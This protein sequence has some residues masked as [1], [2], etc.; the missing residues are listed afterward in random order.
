MSRQESIA[1]SPDGV[2]IETERL[3]LRPHR[4]ADLA[5]LVELASNWEVARWLT[6]VPHPYGEADASAWISRVRQEHE[7]GRPRLF[8]IAR[9]SDDRLIGNAG[10]GRRK[11]DEPNGAVLG[12]WLGQPF[13]GQGYG[14]EAVAALTDYAFRAFEPDCVTAFTDP[15]N[16]ASQKLLLACGFVRSGEIDLPKPL[17]Q[18][19]SRVPLFRVSRQEWDGKRS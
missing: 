11:S 12:Y 18:G 13:W 5:G 8:A 9:K 6:T 16:T 7:T 2:V 15:E 17:R 1:A 14:R 4:E 19:A 10:I 3:R